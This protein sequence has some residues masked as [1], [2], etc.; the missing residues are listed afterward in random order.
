[1]SEASADVAEDIAETIDSIP[2][3][4]EVTNRIISLVNDD[5]T[6]IED[7]ERAIRMDQ[8]LSAAVLRFANN[9]TPDQKGQISDLEQ[10]IQ[11]LGLNKIRSIAL[12]YGMDQH[13]STSE[14]RL[15]PR[16]EFWNY[17][18]A[19]G[20]C[21]ELIAEKIGFTSNRKKQAFSAGHLHC[22]G[23]AILDQHMHTEFEKILQTARKNEIPMI[24]AE[25]EVLGTTHCEIGARVLDNWNLPQALV[26][27]CRYY[28][29][30][31][32]A[33]DKL[34]TVVHLASV[35]TK[36]KDY[37][38]SGDEFFDYLNEREVDKLRLDDDQLRRLLHSE[39][40]HRYEK[41]KD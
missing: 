35:L 8:S 23:K 26:K 17:S 5:S 12:S 31:E 6:P 4:P 38:Q 7:I 2:S 14:S 20:I 11:M 22:G 9:S 28:I 40:P 1:M 36:S 33:D 29:E 19:V 16:E 27:T 34:V 18:L 39:F 13:Y 25:R 15:F 21:S 41:F 3:L 10:A 30:P 24:K 32:K 37:G